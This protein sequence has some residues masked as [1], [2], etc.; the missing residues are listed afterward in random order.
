MMMPQQAYFERLIDP[1]KHAARTRKNMQLARAKASGSH[2]QKHLA[3]SAGL[4][5]SA[6]IPLI[7]K[8]RDAWANCIFSKELFLI[9][10]RVP[11]IDSCRINKSARGRYRHR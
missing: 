1:Q 4:T 2:P 11:A 8:A 9:R 7:S 5:G 3:R 6:K 10:G